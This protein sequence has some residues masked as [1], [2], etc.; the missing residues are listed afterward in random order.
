VITV[1]ELPF[2]AGDIC[3][4]VLPVADAERAHR[5]YGDLL[6]WRFTPGNVEGGS[7]IE[8]SSPPGGM[9]ES[10]DQGGPELYFM[11]DDLDAARERVRQL[12]GEAEDPQPTEGG[13]FSRCRD[14]QGARFGLWAPN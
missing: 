14:D 6:G 12:G 1:P 8:G 3:Y 9:F 5:F 11:V 4:F 10:D 13:R 7:N 2:K